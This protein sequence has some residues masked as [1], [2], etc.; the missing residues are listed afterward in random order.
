MAKAK[1]QV[2][3]LKAGESTLTYEQRRE[4]DAGVKAF[5][6]MTR[7][8]QNGLGIASVLS[9]AIGAFTPDMAEKLNADVRKFVASKMPGV[10]REVKLTG[11][12]DSELKGVLSLQRWQN[13]RG[14]MDYLV[15]INASLAS[16]VAV[17]NWFRKN[18][19]KDAVCPDAA[20][21]LKAINANRDRKRGKLTG[22]KAIAAMEKRAKRDPG[23][24]VKRVGEYLTAL[25]T[26]YGSA[27]GH[28]FLSAMVKGFEAYE[29]FAD[30]LAKAAK[31][32]KD[33]PGAADRARIAEL[34]AQL[35]K[36]TAKP[37]K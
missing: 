29:P 21:I 8:E 23:G 1:A 13:W 5:D 37:K 4:T 34:E 2:T 30:D 15:S 12:R 3:E 11:P 36:L 32:E 26:V 24:M 25:A 7:F 31:A 14:L 19:K 35:A 9:L 6:A 10:T 18:Y 33:N 22:K 16:V 17:S 28:E 20:V 27:A